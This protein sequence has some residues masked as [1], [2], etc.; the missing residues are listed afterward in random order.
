MNIKSKHESTQFY[1]EQLKYTLRLNKNRLT[2]GTKN[3]VNKND[4]KNNFV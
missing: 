1:V 2:Q 3:F 4:C